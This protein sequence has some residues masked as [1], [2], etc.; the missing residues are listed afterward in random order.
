MS[1]S[2]HSYFFIYIEI[3]L[4]T[5]LDM[6]SNTLSCENMEFHKSCSRLVQILLI[7]EN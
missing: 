6:H 5:Y 4:F 1:C 7:S 2:N 3:E